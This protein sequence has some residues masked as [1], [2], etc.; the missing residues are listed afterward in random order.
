[1]YRVLIADDEPMIR[2]GLAKL[3]GER[4]DLVADIHTARNG[5]EA[6]ERISEDPRIFCSRTSACREWMELSCAAV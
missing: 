2:Q 1:M 6:L 3:I 5:Q 4:T